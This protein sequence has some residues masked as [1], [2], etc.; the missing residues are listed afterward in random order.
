MSGFELVRL[1]FD[2]VDA[3]PGFVDWLQRE[4]LAIALTKGNSLC[5]VGLDADGAVAVVDQQFGTCLGLTAL[6]ST[7]IYLATRYQ[8]WRLEN[9]LPEGRLTDDGHDRMFL[10]QSAWTTG[11]VI[12]RDLAVTG[13]GT[14]VFVNGLFSCLSVPSARLSFAATWLPPFVSELAPEERCQLT[15]LALAG[16]RPAFVTSASRSDRMGGWVDQ[17]RDGGVVASVETGELVATGLSVPYSPVLHDGRLWLC[18][19]GSGELAVLDPAGGE[20]T[21]VAELPGFA[22]GLALHGDRAVVA[23]SRAARNESFAALPLSDRLTGEEAE[24]R[25]GIYVVELSSGRVEHWLEFVGGAREIHALAL[26]PGVRSA[27]AVPFS[28]D[29]V[30]ELVTLPA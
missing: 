19:G 25:T 30:Q 1:A 26:L 8:I 12:V 28:G 22:R 20:V 24:G 10:P 16:G 7:T 14:V 5:F 18:L 3:S 27:T 6:G 2:E 13:D 21:R 15:G 29:D 4:R 9:A 17:Q 23:T 11:K